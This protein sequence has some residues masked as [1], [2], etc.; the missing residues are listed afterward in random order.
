MDDIKYAIFNGRETLFESLM[1]D[2]FTF[3]LL[4]LCIYISQGSKWWTF[5]TG[6]LFICVFS[7]KIALTIKTR[8]IRFKTKEELQKWVDGIEEC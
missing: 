6:L 4:A 8:Y 3:S 5:F 1:K 7:S 2:F